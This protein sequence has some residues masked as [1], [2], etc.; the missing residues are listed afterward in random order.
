MP[1]STK[2]P[3]VAV[4]AEMLLTEPGREQLAFDYLYER[5]D[6][7]VGDVI[8]ANV[9]TADVPQSCKDDFFA[10]VEA[11]A[12]TVE[13]RK[14]ACLAA[15]KGIRQQHQTPDAEL[16]ALMTIDPVAPTQPVL[17]A[18]TNEGPNGP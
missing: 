2:Y 3:R 17:D 9:T 13:E 1:T 11:S 7:H 16:E 12:N 8:V 15:A 5:D 10:K 14:K 6:P 4:I 18:P